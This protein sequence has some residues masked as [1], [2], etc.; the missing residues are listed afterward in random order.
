LVELTWDAWLI[1]ALALAA[2]GLTKGITGLGLPA[3]AVPIMAS[4]LGVKDAVMIMLFPTLVTNAWL[5]WKERDT[6]VEVPE[7]PSLLLAG[8]PGVALGAVVLYISSGRFLET[9]LSIWVLVY[10]LLRFLRPELRL[11]K[12][13]RRHF[14]PP[15]GFACGA[16]QGATGICAPVLVPYVDA[17]GV[18]PRTY[19]FAFSSVFMFLGF[20]HITMLTIFGAFPYEQVIQS[21]MAVVP[22]MLFVPIGRWLRQYIPPDN[23]GSLIRVVLFV[24]AV[25]L[26][27]GAWLS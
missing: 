8:I 24:T 15:V 13:S 4:F 17:L 16:L 18:G 12:Q 6:H 1:I 10:L 7:L 14:A 22:A 5:A 9:V 23:F 27:Y 20:G 2:G 25:R 21:L 3:V 26:F 19:V 11:S